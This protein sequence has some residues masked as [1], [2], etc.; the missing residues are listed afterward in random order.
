MSPSQLDYFRQKLLSA[1]REVLK[2]AQKMLDNL[3]QETQEVDPGDS[4]SREI[5]WITE[6]SLLTREQQQLNAIDEALERIQEGSYGY[7]EETGDPIAVDRL[8]AYPTTKL[9]W[10]AQKEQER[11]RK[12]FRGG[13]GIRSVSR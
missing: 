4:I 7:C 3:Q 2:E 9:S 8:E 12:L 1:R 6:C 10:E 13:S 11:R 5:A